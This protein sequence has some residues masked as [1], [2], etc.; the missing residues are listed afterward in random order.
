MGGSAE[1]GRDAQ[2]VDALPQMSLLSVLDSR[3]IKFVRTRTH[4]W[5]MPFIGTNLPRF[6]TM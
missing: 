1:R 6:S 5:V 2:H 4:F 3:I